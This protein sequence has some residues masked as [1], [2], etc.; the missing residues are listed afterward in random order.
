MDREKELKSDEGGVKGH[1][2]GDVKLTGEELS[3][4]EKMVLEERKVE[5]ERRGIRVCDLEE[6]NSLSLAVEESIGRRE[7]ER[8]AEQHE[9]SKNSSTDAQL[10]VQNKSKNE[11]E[12]E[13]QDGRETA[14]DTDEN[15]NE[16]EF[17][18]HL[19]NYSS[20]G[21]VTTT[22]NPDSPIVVT[23]ELSIW[24]LLLPQDLSLRIILFLG[25]VDM[26]GY[27]MQIAKTNC[28]K[29][30]ELIFKALCERIY[31]SQSKKKLMIVEN[32]KTWRNMLVFRPRIRTNGFYSLRTLYSRAPSNDSFW[33]E[34]ITQS[35]E[36]KFC[37]HMRFFDNGRMLYSLDT[38]EPSL[39]LS[40]FLSFFLSLSPSL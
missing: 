3:L 36:V 29:P 20:N 1:V 21:A 8:Q 2:K 27:L 35:V 11:N 13:N 38:V 22:S 23:E 28:F 32:W 16:N 17:L 24:Q 37:R 14:D 15:E 39:S 9:N 25:D 33:E 10:E 34:K 19:D 7:R 4:W 31:T 5:A 26:C 18:D 30:T 12:N 40:L 6:E